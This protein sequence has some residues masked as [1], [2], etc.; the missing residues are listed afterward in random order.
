MSTRIAVIG[1]GIAGLV[2]AREIQRSGREP[3]LFEA[4]SEPGGHTN[5]VT[6]ESDAGA[7]NVDTGFIVYNDRNYTN[8]ERLLTKLGVATQ[9]APMSFSVSDGLGDFE[10]SLRPLG[11]F[12]NHR[13][14]FDPR[15]HKMLLELP[16]FFREA[17]SLVGTN[18]SGGSLRSFLESRGYSDYFIERLILPQA[19]AVWSADP[20]QMWSFPASFLAEFF[21]HHGALQ[22]RDR[23]RWRSIR[24]GSRRYV[25]KLIAPYADRI[26][27]STPVDCVTRH[28]DRVEVRSQ[29]GSEA[30]DEIVI[31]THSDQALALLG[32]PSRAELEILGSIPYQ[33]NDVV[34][35]TDVALMPRRRRAWGSWN[36]HLNPGGVGRTT[37][38]YDMNRLQGL[39][40]DR[41]FLVT[42]NRSEAID[43]AKVIRRMVYSHPIYTLAGVEAQTRWSEISG[44][45]RTHYCGA[46]WGWGF[47][48]DG[49]VS[50]LRA[51]ARMGS[52]ERARAVPQLALAGAA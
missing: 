36:F 21:H 30:F 18:G 41:R 14:L 28:P 20:D 19:S 2:A 37:V 43:P 52:L 24:D 9:P 15:F 35:H 12:A 3:I 27:T 44:H 26:R 6:I 33:R 45:R 47:H 39:R 13:H 32:D 22:I 48:E 42:L 23:P 8:F 4:G 51:C 5:T 17:R 25:E 49:V 40:A 1:T 34:L 7:W 10:W 46:Y 50:A 11:V 38:T 16:R 31:A 29:A